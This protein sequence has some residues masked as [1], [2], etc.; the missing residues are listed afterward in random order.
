M[1]SQL[2]S[3]VRVAAGRIA[4]L[5]LLLSLAMTAD[6]RQPRWV[7]AWGT[8]QQMLADVGLANTT[9][10]MIAR[11]TIPGDAVRL[12]LDNTYG[13]VPVTIGRA[14]VGWRK[15][16]AAIWPGSNRP[17]LFSGTP[18][19]AIPAG[20]SVESDPVELKVQPRQDLAVSLFVPGS[21]IH[22]S[23]HA[24]SV[25]TSY[26]AP[27]GS[28]D[29]LANDEDT[30]FSATTRA[31]LWLKAIDVR[32]TTASGAIVA[33]GDSIT[34][35]SCSTMDGYDRWTDW[36][37]VRLDMAGW[38]MAVVNEGIGGN[39]VVGSTIPPIGMPGVARLDRDVLS[40][41]GVT[42]VVLFMGTNDVRRGTTASQVIAGLQD[43]VKRAR[44]REIKVIGATMIPRASHP[45]A[46]W[47]SDMTKTR[48]DI[49]AWMRI[50]GAVDGVIEFDK[51]MMDPTNPDV[52][53]MPFDC[54]A[55][56]PGPRGYY[57]MGKSISLDLFHR[58]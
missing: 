5:V 32:S 9:V 55:V 34:E 46:P 20:G 7:T 31:G 2:T 58:P 21:D 12:R 4:P 11:V 22:A 15:T 36:L 37:G 27:S 56:H 1:N 10:R 30:L 52:L 41:N 47:T 16:G 57:E 8:S 13:M 38:K 17:V 23:Q 28:G 26:L 25:V 24:P 19:V 6:G 54:D 42:H 35:G 43:I 50:Q 44:A 49:N 45:R 33:F 51:V 3:A 53:F 14:H 29:V 18:S 48:H 40:H 39:T